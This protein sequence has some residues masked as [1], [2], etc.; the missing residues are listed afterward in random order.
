MANRNFPSQRVFSFHMMPVRI[1]GSISIG[2]TGAV[3]STSG[4]GVAS[5]TRVGTGHYQIVLQ[6]PFNA[7]LSLSARMKAV[8][9]TTPSGIASVELI[10]SAITTATGGTVDIMTIDKTGVLA[11]PAS[12][13]AIQFE[14]S[15]NNSSVQ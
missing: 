10:S 2:A 13:S 14:L 6:D 5:A 3:S 11:D 4:K 8:N 12:G 15:L 9:A 7:L 1:D